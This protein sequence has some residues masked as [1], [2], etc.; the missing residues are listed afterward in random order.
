MFLRVASLGRLAQRSSCSRSSS[1]DGRSTT[2]PLLALQ[3]GEGVDERL[4][5]FWELAPAQVCSLYCVLYCM[6]MLTSLH[7][8]CRHHCRPVPGS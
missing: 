6:L 7:L 8:P 3:V 5:V 4:L 1:V 2:A